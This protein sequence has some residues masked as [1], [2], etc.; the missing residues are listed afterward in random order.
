MAKTKEVDR[1]FNAA[2][3]VRLLR[4]KKVSIAM[5]VKNTWKPTKTHIS[6]KTYRALTLLSVIV[7]RK[8]SK[9]GKIWKGI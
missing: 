3:V 8:L 5:Y 1:A 6:W 9:E 4:S 2:T 7:A